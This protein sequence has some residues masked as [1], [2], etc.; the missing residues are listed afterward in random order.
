[1]FTVSLHRPPTALPLYFK[2]I[3]GILGAAAAATGS[4]AAGTLMPVADVPKVHRITTSTG[5][6]DKRRIENAAKL[7]SGIAR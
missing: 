1:V 3:S 5:L 7:P 2:T 4:A 6:N